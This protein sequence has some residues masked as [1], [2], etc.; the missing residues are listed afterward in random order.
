MGSLIMP[1]DPSRG[2]NKMRRMAIREE[3][4]YSFY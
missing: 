1:E 2:L 4:T 3:N